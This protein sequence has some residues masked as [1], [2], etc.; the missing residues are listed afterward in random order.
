MTNTKKVLFVLGGLTLLIVGF[1]LGSLGS[2][3]SYGAVVGESLS[4]VGEIRNGYANTLLFKDGIWQNA[5][6][7]T[8]ITNSGTLIQ[9]GA[10]TLSGTTIVTGNLTATGTVAIS[11]P[12]SSTLKIGNNNSG[13][14][15]GCLVLGD[16]AGATSS[17]VYITATGATLS[18]TTTK[19]AICK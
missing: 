9:S 10:A 17:P 15:V 5:P 18:A 8:G 1:A 19:P 7:S 16:S 4:V 11:Q 2:K 12:A 3:A 14:G 13:I 6:I